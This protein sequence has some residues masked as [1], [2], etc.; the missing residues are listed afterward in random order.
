M[1][2]FGQFPTDFAITVASQVDLHCGENENT[3]RLMESTIRVHEDHENAEEIKV[4]VDQHLRLKHFQQMAIACELEDAMVSYHGYEINDE[5]KQML[6]LIHKSTRHWLLG[7]VTGQIIERLK[8]ER[9][10]NKDFAQLAVLVFQNLLDGEQSPEEV[11]NTVKGHLTINT[12]P[13]EAKIEEP[14]IQ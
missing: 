5:Q 12:L 4:N 3:L 9:I 10:A 8:S 1:S 11:F 6:E 13:P 7:A 14:Q 2:D